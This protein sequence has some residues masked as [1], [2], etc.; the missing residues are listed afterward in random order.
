MNSVVSTAD[1]CEVVELVDGST[2]DSSSIGII[3]SFVNKTDLAA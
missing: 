2:V 1:N 3:T